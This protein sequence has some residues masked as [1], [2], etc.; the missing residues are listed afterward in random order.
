MIDWTSRERQVQQNTSVFMQTNVDSDE[1]RAAKSSKTK[2]KR[3]KS[4]VLRV[5]DARKGAEVSLYEFAMDEI[6]DGLRLILENSSQVTYENQCDAYDDL[7]DNAPEECEDD[8]DCV[9][10]DFFNNLPE[11]NLYK[12][13]TQIFKFDY[14]IILVT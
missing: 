6:P 14:E 7:M 9:L 4:G 2:Q 1:G 8:V 3:K 11:K 12:D 5:T 13:L 10:D